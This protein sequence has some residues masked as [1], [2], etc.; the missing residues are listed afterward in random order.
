MADCD[1][2]KPPPDLERR[3]ILAGWNRPHHD[4]AGQ[5]PAGADDLGLAIDPASWS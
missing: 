4:P 2:Q 3:G 1:A 5:E